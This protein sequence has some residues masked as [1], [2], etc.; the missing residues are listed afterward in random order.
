[1]SEWPASDG[2][3]AYLSKT[4]RYNDIELGFDESVSSR[5]LFRLWLRAFLVSFTTWF[6][7]AVFA[8]IIGITSEDPSSSLGL[9][10]FGILISFLM[11]WF[12]MLFTKLSE[13]IAEWRVL[14]AD[15][16]DKADSAYSCIS[17]TLR[18]RRSPIG[19][20]VRR[21]RT[22][23]GQ[24]NVSNRL[25]MSDRSYTAYV[26]VFG[27]GTSLYLGWMM[28][29]S[30]R[31]TSLI[32]QYLKDLGEGL[33]GRRDL[34]RMMLRTERPRAMREAVHSACREGL[35]TAAH[36]VEVPL[37][38]G[39]PQ[40]LPPIEAAEIGPAPMPVGP[41]IPAGHLTGP[42]RQ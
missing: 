19:Y 5:T 33:T 38:Y 25:V 24:D 21:I 12:I 15:R 2:N 29:R 39:F 16:A 7:F 36:G 27:Y 28:W 40:G 3:D 14:V 30:R 34:E 1:M 35:F 26:S 37:N 31:G 22:G 17:G 10:S 23:F 13:P 18:D 32:G 20:S 4:L 11:F 9:L 8:A 42:P 6:V 41:P